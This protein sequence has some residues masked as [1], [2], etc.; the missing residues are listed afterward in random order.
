MCP[1]TERE[2]ELVRAAL[3]AMHDRVEVRDTTGRVVLLNRAM[4]DVAGPGPPVPP[5]PGDGDHLDLHA[6]DGTLLGAMV[7]WRGVAEDLDTARV[8]SA[9]DVLTG[10]P[11]RAM[12]VQRVRSAMERGR[13]HSW[14]T[15]VLALNLDRFADLAARMGGSS[16]DELLALVG[17]RV[18]SCLRGADTILGPPGT[19][20]R[21]GA[22]SSSCCASTSRTP[23]RPS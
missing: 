17:T 5:S 4:E 6:A 15:A 1:G 16:G 2:L 22:T 13:R 14:C 21:L 11:S 10:L 19:V 23:A 8:R 9:R 3:D 7:C 18:D 12:F 20:T